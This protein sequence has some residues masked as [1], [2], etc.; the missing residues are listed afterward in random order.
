MAKKKSTN[1]RL[2]AQRLP[3]KVKLDD[4]PRE[5]DVALRV[6]WADLMEL[7]VR[8][9]IPVAMLRFYAALP[10]KLIEQTRI[11][12]SV[13]HLR[14]MIDVLCKTTDYYPSKPK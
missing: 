11:Q 10:D 8:G 4:L 12:T 7:S 6:M 1:S 2:K 13:K 5:S 14:G 3:R 9:D